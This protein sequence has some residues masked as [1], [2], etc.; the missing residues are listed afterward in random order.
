MKQRLREFRDHLRATQK[1]IADQL[2]ISQSAFSEY[3]R[4]VREIPKRLRDKIN[5]MF[6]FDIGD[7]DTLRATLAGS[8]NTLT[9]E[10]CE[11]VI[12]YIDFI[13]FKSED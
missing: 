7:I 3:E 2:G 4:G 6:N 11:E 5:E 10:Q 8:V 12:K 1:A 13:K 9:S